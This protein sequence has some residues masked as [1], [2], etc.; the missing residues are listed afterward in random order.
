MHSQKF[1]GGSLS[2]DWWCPF[3]LKSV[4]HLSRSAFLAE[5]QIVC[6]TRPLICHACNAQTMCT[7]SSLIAHAASGSDVACVTRRT[8]NL[9]H[10]PNMQANRLLT[11]VS[12]DV[13]NATKGKD[14]CASPASHSSSTPR[15]RMVVSKVWPC[16]DVT[17]TCHLHAHPLSKDKWCCLWHLL[18]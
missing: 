12:T 9:E 18:A 2:S 16:S 13:A 5:E 10:S 8:C 11:I 14:E 1:R 7:P 17:W 4:H 6:E 3:M 15:R